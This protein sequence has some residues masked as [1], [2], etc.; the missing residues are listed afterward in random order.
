M[1][2][3]RRNLAWASLIVLAIVGWYGWLRPPDG[4]EWE[5][6]PRY[7]GKT[8]RFAGK[9]KNGYTLWYTSRGFPS[10]NYAL[11]YIFRI[12]DGASVYV[13]DLIHYVAAE[14][15]SGNRGE[16]RKTLV[17]GKFEIESEKLIV[18]GEGESIPIPDFLGDGDWELGVLGFREEKNDLWDNPLVL[19]RRTIRFQ[20]RRE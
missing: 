5:L 19:S 7:D 14:Q 12:S 17:S 9:V 15:D 18:D 4:I 11:F 2:I 8:L 3:S 6:E 13:V 10:V 1:N 16:L 20:E